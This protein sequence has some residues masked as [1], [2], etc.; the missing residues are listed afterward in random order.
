MPADRFYIPRPLK[1]PLTIEGDELH[2]LSKV[3]RIRP[4]E[5]LEIV[6]GMGDLA[7]A[8]V[9][10]LDKKS[11][12]LKIV[13]HHHGKPE[14]PLIL[15][16]ALTRSLDWIIEKGTEL[17]VTEFWLF[18]GERSEKKELSPTQ[19]H[20][21]E[22]LTITALKQCGRLFLPKIQLKSPLDRWTAPQGSLFFGDVSPKAP[23][24]K[25]PFSSPVV[26]FIGPEKGF[27]PEEIDILLKFKARGISLHE[28][29]LRAETAA[30]AALSQFYIS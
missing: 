23:I 24:L 1:D 29:I 3:M 12:R 27:S 21:L 2:H 18:P 6:N 25:G 17:G 26:F 11:A 30:L 8:E 10:I 15:A 19:L 5:T 22:T 20:R 4:G 9:A 7:I 16:Q 28:N 13:S 14:R